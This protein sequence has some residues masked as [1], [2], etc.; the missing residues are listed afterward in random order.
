[1]RVLA[2]G[3]RRAL[4]VSRTADVFHVFEALRD[5]ADY[6]VCDT[7]ALDDGSEGL[8]RIF[9]TPEPR[10]IS[11][12]GLAVAE[13]CGKALLVASSATSLSQARWAAGLLVDEGVSVVGLVVHE[14]RGT[15]PPPSTVDEADE[16]QS[17]SLSS[18]L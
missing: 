3:D 8:G 18:V 1:L 9:D 11:L 14:S 15:H 6:I 5:E 7:C 17:V 16:T 12:D 10:L 4:G 13:A 2:I